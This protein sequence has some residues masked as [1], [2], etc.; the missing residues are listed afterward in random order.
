MTNPTAKPAGDQLA[1]VLSDLAH[2]REQREDL[3]RRLMA[4]SEACNDATNRIFAV[5]TLHVRN[6]HST[7][8]RNDSASSDNGDDD[9]KPVAGL[10]GPPST[11]DDYYN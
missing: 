7:G 10:D 6:E 2:E 4:T 5:R 11:E 9:S 1:R 3:R 8:P